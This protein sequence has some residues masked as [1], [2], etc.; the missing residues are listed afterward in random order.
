VRFGPGEVGVLVTEGRVAVAHKHD[1]TSAVGPPATS[2]VVLKPHDQL[3]VPLNAPAAG[4]QI[5]TASPQAMQAALAWR[6]MR[7]EITDIPLK[8]IA[9]IFNEINPVRLEVDAKAADVRISGIYWLDDP[10]GF[11]RLVES[12]AS[13]RAIQRTPRSILLTPP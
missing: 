6:A 7:V 8:E 10:E 11:A 9:R 13:L 5:Q 1:G 12:S 2:S 4:F 3:T